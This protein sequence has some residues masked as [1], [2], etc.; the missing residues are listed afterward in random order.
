[1]TDRTDALKELTEASERYEEAEAARLRAHEAVIAAALDAL[2]AGAR[3]G[4]VYD[5]VP[6]TSTHIRTLAR[7]A[8][9]PAGPPGKPRKVSIPVPKARRDS[10]RD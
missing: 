2:R 1:M 9:I 8:G 4:E 5:R 7:E 10:K 3:P 6:F